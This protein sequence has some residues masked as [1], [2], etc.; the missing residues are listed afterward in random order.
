[1]K[2]QQI[3]HTAVCMV[4][5]MIIFGRLYFCSNRIERRKKSKPINVGSPPCQA[6]V[7]GG[8]L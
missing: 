1:M 8:I 4:F 2:L 3:R 6:M 7:A 5:R